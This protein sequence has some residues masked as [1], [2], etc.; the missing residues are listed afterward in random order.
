MHRASLAN[1]WYRSPTL[2]LIVDSA[3]GQTMSREPSRNI[4]GELRDAGAAILLHHGE[5]T[6]HLSAYEVS[7][8]IG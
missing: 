7:I 5:L 1:L 8:A 2:A 6:Q 3:G 4:D